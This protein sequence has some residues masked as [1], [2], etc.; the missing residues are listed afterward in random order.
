VITG[1]VNGELIALDAVTGE[2]KYQS[3]LGV[4]AIDGGVVTYEA[5]GKQFLAVAAGDNNATYKAKGDN[6]IVILA[7]P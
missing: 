3:D 1:D 2:L 7:L 6:T 5:K 4:G